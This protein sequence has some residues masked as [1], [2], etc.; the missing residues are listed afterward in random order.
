MSERL[1]E[2]Y[3]YHWRISSE[4]WA[5]ARPFVKLMKDEYGEELKYCISSCFDKLDFGVYN[6]AQGHKNLDIALSAAAGSLA[7]IA[8]KI[9]G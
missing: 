6:T 9:Y 1:P 5:M 7:E 2:R 3:W 8:E 4:L